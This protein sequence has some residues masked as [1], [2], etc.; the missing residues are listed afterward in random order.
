MRAVVIREHGDPDALAVEDRP[1]P[2]PGPGEVRVRIRAAALNHLDLWVRKGVPGVRYPLP[3]VPGCDGSGIVD[4]VGDG[5]AGIEPG[6]PCVLAPGVSCGRCEACSRGTDHLCRWYGILGEH[7]DGTCAD[8]IVVPARNVLPKPE[9]LSFE[10]AAAF[11]LSFLTAWHMVFERARLRPGETVLVHAAG[12]GVS[13][14][15]IQMADLLGARILATAGSEEKLA[16]ARDLGAEETV[17]YR[18]ADFAVEVRRLTGKRGADVILDHV[19]RDTWDGNI[20]SLARG[21]RLVICGNTSGRE[22]VTSLPHVFFKNL[23]ILGSTMGSRAE[24]YEIIRLLER[25]T[26]T[27]VVDR[28]LPMS[29]IREAHRVLEDREAFGKVVVTP[30]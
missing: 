25:E 11:G 13:T 4:R 29:D 6:S 14:A 16:R 1:D 2:E 8:F 12:S 18:A 21:G 26:L 7:R 5:V 24:L 28:V 19:G 20:R 9:N 30:W 3:L 22:A 10:E 15:A 17:N 27:P 23:S